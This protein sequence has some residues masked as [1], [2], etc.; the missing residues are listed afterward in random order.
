[1]GGAGAL[2]G[3]DFWKHLF[4]TSLENPSGAPAFFHLSNI[5]P[6]L[7]PLHSFVSRIFCYLSLLTGLIFV[8]YSLFLFFQPL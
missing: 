8:A 3:D 4:G 1:M 2:M 5:I 6:P 7:Y